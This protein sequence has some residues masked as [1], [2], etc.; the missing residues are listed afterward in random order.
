MISANAKDLK[1][2]FILWFNIKFLEQ[3]L[4]CFRG[5]DRGE[6]GRR[7]SIYQGRNIY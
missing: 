3:Y 2:V 5:N 4:T 1:K 6:N 7:K